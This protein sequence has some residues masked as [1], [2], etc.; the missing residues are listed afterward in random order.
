M[1]D[2]IVYV[3]ILATQHFSALLVEQSRKLLE[4]PRVT[5]NLDVLQPHGKQQHK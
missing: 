5:T 3:D 4:T 2:K 1:V